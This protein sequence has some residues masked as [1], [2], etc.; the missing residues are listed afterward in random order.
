MIDHLPDYFNGT[1]LLAAQ[2]STEHTQSTHHNNADA[3]RTPHHTLLEK[4]SS[5]EVA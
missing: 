2:S 3:G 1:L 5:P 4:L